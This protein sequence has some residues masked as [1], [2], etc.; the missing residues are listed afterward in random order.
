V[1]LAGAC[2][3]PAAALLQSIERHSPIAWMALGTGVLNL[4]LSIAFVGPYGLEG[5][6]TATLLASAVEITV[7][8]VPYA[9][10]VLGV[11]WREF[12]SEVV[13]PLLLPGAVLAGLV[14]AGSAILPV[15]SLVR[16]AVVVGVAVTG[17]LFAYARVGAS[18][19][20]RSVYRAALSAG[21]GPQDSTIK[22]GPTDAQI[23][24]DFAAGRTVVIDGW[25]LSVTE[26]RQ[27]ALFSLTP[28]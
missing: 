14:I 16:L 26:A 23:R 1:C 5:V 25:V 10:R 19:H 17:Y 21:Q 13:L 6:A 7:F 3:Y 24:G 8:V 12:A 28:A 11:S 2:R 15:T 18:P 4:G 20:E 22:N 27:A 9:A